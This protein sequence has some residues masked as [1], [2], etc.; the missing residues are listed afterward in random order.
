MQASQTTAQGLWLAGVCG[1]VVGL[2]IWFGGPFAV[3][4]MQHTIL[5]L[6]LDGLNVRSILRMLSQA[7]SQMSYQTSQAM[8]V[9]GTHV[10]A[11]MGRSCIARLT[12]MLS[13]HI[14]PISEMYCLYVA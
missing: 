12:L 6:L 9:L 7:W 2:A 4:G 13:I 1:V 10:K 8:T 3:T 14:L 5:W 11:A